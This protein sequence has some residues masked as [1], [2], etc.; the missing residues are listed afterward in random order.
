MKNFVLALVAGSVFGF[1][2]FAGEKAQTPAKA[3]AVA[4]CDC[5]CQVVEVARRPL[6]GRRNSCNGCSTCVE[7]VMVPATKT[8]TVYETKKVLVEKEVKVPVKKEVTTLV[9]AKVVAAPVCQTVTVAP[10]RRIGSRLRGATANVVD[11]VTCK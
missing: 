7:T 1:T 3:Q 10:V 2:A 5:N 4:A 11:C 9:P 8:V 6:L